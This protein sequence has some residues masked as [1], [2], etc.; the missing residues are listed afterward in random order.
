M[1]IA[2]AEAAACSAVQP[3]ESRV[4]QQVGK[5]RSS[6]TISITSPRRAILNRMLVALDSPPRRPNMSDDAR[7]YKYTLQCGGTCSARRVSLLRFE[8]DLCALI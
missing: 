6:T 1:S 4:S 8:N 7:R 5:R 3:S 2:P